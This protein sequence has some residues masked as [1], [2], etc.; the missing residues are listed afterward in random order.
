MDLRAADDSESRFA[1]YVE[2]HQGQPASVTVR[3]ARSRRLVLNGVVASCR[4][5]T[6]ASI[7]RRVSWRIA[8]HIAQGVRT[9]LVAHAHP[10]VGACALIAIVSIPC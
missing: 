8:V 1:G 6:L 2:G 9:L 7:A 4:G 5:A 3:T 10:S